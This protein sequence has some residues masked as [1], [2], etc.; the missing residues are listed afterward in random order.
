MLLLR[1]SAVR[2]DDVGNLRLR[3][4]GPTQ[5][6][7]SSEATATCAIRTGLSPIAARLGESVTPPSEHFGQA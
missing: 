2:Y 5:V 1:L 3:S 6:A 7:K 4:R